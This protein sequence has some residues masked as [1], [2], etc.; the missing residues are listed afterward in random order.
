MIVEN[1][2]VP[3]D[4]RI[5][6]E[7][8]ALYAAGYRVS[9]ICPQAEGYTEAYAEIDGIAIHR[10][11]LPVEAESAIGYPIE[12]ATA[13]FWQ[14]RLARRI[15]R[16]TPVDVIHAANP[17]DTAFIVA[18]LARLAG[19][20]FVFDHHDLCPELFEAKFGRRGT[21]YWLLRALERA[22]FAT[23]SVSIATNDSFKRIA[24]RR[25]GMAAENVFVVRSGPNL[26]RVYPVAPDP[27]LKR[28]RRHLVGYVGVMGEQEGLSDLL[29]VIAD[30][31]YRRERHDIQFCLVGFGP[32]LAGLKHEAEALGIAEYV[33]FPGRLAGEDLLRVLSTA[34][35]CV[36][37]DPKNAMND[38]STMNK[39]LEYMALGKPLV[40]YDLVEGRVSAGEAA[41][42][43]QPGNTGHFADQLLAL[44]DDAPRRA[45]MGA[46]GR[47]RIEAELAW[48]HE[49]PTLL[50]AYER[51]WS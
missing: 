18:A 11:P 34:D 23:A 43:A 9:V 26:D 2:P 15:H 29:A 16:E 49:V 1:L 3:F 50:A 28:G 25:G 51:V 39:I 21:A 36:S 5:W 17:P 40:Q 7:A 35:V 6:Q 33:D 38:Q 47:A 42:Y 48:P 22:T 8:N 37:P 27:T 46:A 13:L 31:V 30:L 20:R 10:H 19:V 45:V 14:L 32:S 4:R 24:C 12:Y 44:I 41:L